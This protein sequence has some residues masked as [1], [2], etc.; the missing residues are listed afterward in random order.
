MEAPLAEAETGSGEAGVEDRG[1]RVT[2]EAPLASEPRSR[3]PPPSTARRRSP[4]DGRHRSVLMFRAHIQA[5]EAAAGGS[6][7]YAE[8]CFVNFDHFT[9]TSSHLY[10]SLLSVHFESS[11]RSSLFHRVIRFL[12]QTLRFFFKNIARHI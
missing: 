7:V 11:L 4:L 9:H 6:S 2:V 8:L 1:S 5:E 10:R 12:L 3:V